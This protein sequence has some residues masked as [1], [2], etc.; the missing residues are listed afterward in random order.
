VALAARQAI[1]VPDDESPRVSIIVPTARQP[2]LLDACLRSLPGAIRGGLPCE[3]LIV[4]NA[5]DEETS[6][7]VRSGVR[8]ARVVESAVNLGVAGAGNLAREAARGELLAF[9]HDDVVCA[10]GCLSALVAVAEKR[11]DAGAVGSRLLHPDGRPQAAGAVV[12]RDGSS[13][14]LPDGDSSGAEVTPADYVMSASMLVRSEVWDT[15]GGM[16]ERFFPA[17]HVDADLGLAVWSAGCSV[18]CACDSRVRHRRG[19]SSSEPFREFLIER[20]RVQLREKWSTVLDGHEVRA[21]EGPEASVA[22]AR[23]RVDAAAEQVRREFRR[24]ARPGASRP[25]ARPNRQARERT[26]V[27]R[28]A[29]VNAAYA[30]ELEARLARLDAAV[31]AER[32]AHRVAADT[33]RR[34]DRAERTLHEIYSGGWWRLRAALLPALRLARR[35]RRRR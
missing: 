6:D 23:A 13:W 18:L 29:A 10:P 4:L 32:R 28:A 34:L 24:A 20:N 15:V 3:T 31:E 19:S 35:L 11:P 27:E 33:A 2:R 25:P 9:L 21:P 17:Y 26:A 5:A 7:L 16:D 1:A 22:R 30:A 8:G 14:P 12:F